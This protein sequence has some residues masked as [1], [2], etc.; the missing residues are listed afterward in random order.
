MTRGDIFQA[1]A[2]LVAEGRGGNNI[3]V[4]YA[5]TF[6]LSSSNMNQTMIDTK[7]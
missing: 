6:Y 7:Y 2:D 4:Y 5:V 3:Q 1:A